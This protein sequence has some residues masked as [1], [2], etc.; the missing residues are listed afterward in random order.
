MKK[1]KQNVVWVVNNHQGISW[2]DEQV[3]YAE[4]EKILIHLLSAASTIDIKGQC[5]NDF[6]R[7]YFD[8]T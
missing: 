2:N 8:V 5:K 6:F 7:E 1:A 4:M 3:E